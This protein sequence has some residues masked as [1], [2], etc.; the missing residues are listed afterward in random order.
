MYEEPDE[1]DNE[2]IQEVN[3]FYEIEGNCYTNE[4]VNPYEEMEAIDTL[5]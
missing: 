2:D 5:I 4:G 1:S 3:H